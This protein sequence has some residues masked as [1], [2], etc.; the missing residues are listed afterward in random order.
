M[1]NILVTGATG[2]LGRSLIPHLKMRGHNIVTQSR[3]EDSDF[4]IDLS[5]KKNVFDLLDQVA[6]TVII[7]LVGLTS[8][9]LC[10]EQ[11]NAAYLANCH[12]VENIAKWIR[13][14][15]LDCHLI[16]MSTDQVYD[17]IGPHSE[18][19]VTVTNNYGFSKYAGELAAALVPS[20]ILR[21]NFIG[22]SHAPNRVS[23]TDWVFES[24]SSGSNIKV[25][26]DVLFSPLSMKTLLVMIDLVIEKMPIGIFNLGS[27]NGMSKADFDFKFAACLGLETK[28]MT[29]VTTE[30]ATF[31]KAYRPKDMRLDC[32][33]IEKELGIILPNLIDEIQLAAKEYRT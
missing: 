15:G 19:A 9:D 2:L 33:K 6:P 26:D 31:L 28:T 29:R 24:L 1:N 8:V 7:N 4:L 3:V 20:T 18:E 17:G 13:Q 25:L 16:Q 12:T 5:D 23:I 11:T 10:Q 30:T 21:T 14:S 32:E 22:L 27:H